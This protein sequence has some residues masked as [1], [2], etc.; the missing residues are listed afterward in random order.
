MQE[1]GGG[2][3]EAEAAASPAAVRHHRRFPLT[4]VTLDG[5]SVGAA[6]VDVWQDAA[7]A[8]FWSARILMT[9][10]DGMSSGALVGWT[11]DGRGL[12]GRVSLGAQAAGA[13]SRGQV[14]V[15]WHGVGPLLESETVRQR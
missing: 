9:P 3:Q 15:E 6:T 13:R 11:R 8:S 12:Q 2:A 10:V 7:G 5:K 1:S 4:D 14:L